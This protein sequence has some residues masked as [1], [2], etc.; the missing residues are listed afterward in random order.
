MIDIVV[1]LQFQRLFRKLHPDLQEEVLEKVER[2]K[3]PANH[4]SLKVHKL[5]GRLKDRYGFSVNYKIRVIFSYPKKSEALLLHVGNN[6][7]YL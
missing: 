4:Q 6:D 5:H 1:S 3:D 2:L 7:V